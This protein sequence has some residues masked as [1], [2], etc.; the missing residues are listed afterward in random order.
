MIARRRAS[1]FKSS[2]VRRK[3]CMDTPV[4]V[5]ELLKVNR[6]CCYLDTPVQVAGGRERSQGENTSTRSRSGSG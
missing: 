2:S 4:Q 6:S 5:G 3:D 1:Y